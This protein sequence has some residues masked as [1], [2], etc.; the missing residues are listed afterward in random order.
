MGFKYNDLRG[1][2]YALFQSQSNFAI[3]LGVTKGTITAKLKGISKFNQDDIVSWSNLLDIKP[4]E[5]G[6]YFFE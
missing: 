6:K 4:E 1:R 5:Y 3:S 2:I